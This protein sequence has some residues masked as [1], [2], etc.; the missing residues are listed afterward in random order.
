[1]TS[2]SKICRSFSIEFLM[3]YA[4]KA[5]L[6]Y[7]CGWSWRCRF[8]AQIFF[9]INSIFN[10]IT[11]SP[12]LHRILVLIPPFLCALWLTSVRYL[13]YSFALHKWISNRAKN[14]FSPVE[15]MHT[16][17]ERPMLT[18][19]SFP[20]LMQNWSESN[21]WEKQ[22]TATAVT[23]AEIWWWRWQRQHHR[24]RQRLQ[25][26]QQQQQWMNEC[27]NVEGKVETW[28]RDGEKREEERWIQATPFTS[29]GSYFSHSRNFNLISVGFICGRIWTEIKQFPK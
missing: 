4:H 3:C 19:S 6:L 28:L 8:G 15:W 7:I 18:K 26:Q 1:M 27:M 25:Q 13:F 21:E 29:S 24:Q 14:Y 9:T 16:R 17:N 20:C 5:I 2:K 23:R 10:Y 22:I 11:I 12:I